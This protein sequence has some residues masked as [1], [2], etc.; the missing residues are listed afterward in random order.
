MK[1]K[2]ILSL[3]LVPVLL[4]LV[5]TT[6]YFA[7]LYTWNFEL[8]ALAVFL[9]T[10]VYIQFFEWLIPLKQEWKVKKKEV[11]TDLK[12]LFISTIPFDA[13]GKMLAIA[14]VLYVQEQ[15]FS[16]FGFWDA[17]PFLLTFVIANL[18]GELLP[19]LYHR[20]SHKGDPGSYLS[21]FLWRI[22]AVHHIPISLNWFK[23]NWIHPINM[24]LNTLLKFLPLLIL[25]FSSEIIFLVGITHVVIAYLSHA[26][27]DTKT[28]WLDYLIVTPKVHQFHHSTKLEE[29]KNFGNILP[30]WDLVFGTYFNRE[31]GVET[32]GVSTHDHFLYPSRKKFWHQLIYPFST[33]V[34]GCCK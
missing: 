20:V 4:I 29:A 10:L 27:I 34:N 9:F 19:Y 23:T 33:K 5:G 22:H 32:V 28:G 7:V 16:K 26:N 1:I 15:F 24:F 8:I 31:K 12:H 14:V 13:V 21:L 25:G 17:I 18:I 11:P 6:A 3:L 30:F 2:D